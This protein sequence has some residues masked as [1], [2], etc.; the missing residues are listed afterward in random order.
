MNHELIELTNAELFAKSLQR[1]GVEY[2]F[3][4][5]NPSKI[6]LACMDLGIKQIGYRQENSGSYMAQ[7]YGMVTGKV[8][9]VTA[10]NGPAATLLVPGLAECLKASHP[11]VA[12]VQQISLE[13]YE[14]NAFQ[15][16]DHEKLFAG[17]A[18]WVKT[19][20]SA[21]RI[22]DYIDMAFTQAATGKPGPAVLLC[23]VNIFNDRN[24]YS[25]ETGRTKNLGY[26]PLDRV[27]ANP[28]K[29][30]EAA[31]LLA[32][33]KKPMIVAGGGAIA[34]DAMQEIREIQDKYSIPVA[35]TMMGKGSVAEEHPLSVGVIGFITGKRGMAKFL[36]PMVQESDVILFVGSRTNQNG[37]DSWTLFPKTAK[38]IH[39]DVD[40]SEIG[41]NYEAL[42]LA[43]D[44]KLT[45]KALSDALVSEDMSGHAEKRKE[46]EEIIAKGKKE[47][48]EE[49]KDVMTSKEL[50][51]RIEHFT[52][53]LEN[54]LREDHIVVADA[55]FS[56]IWLA[57]YI[58]ATAE[59]KFI[60]PRGIA[61]LGWGLPMAMGAKVGKPNRKVFCMAGDGGFAHVWSELETCRR[62]G[63]N[64]VCAVINNE[65]LGY[66]YWAELSKFDG[67][68]TNACDLSPVNHAK[69]AE[70]CGIK[71][72]RLED[73]NDIDKVLEE[74]M[75][76]DG[77][78]VIDIRATGD[79]IPPVRI[80]ESFDG[81]KYTPIQE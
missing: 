75:N 80:M 7:A 77:C 65:V 42:R 62:H 24:K 43:G 11:I 81:S 37:T 22:E 39:I 16:L 14:K 40:G 38:Y 18:K 10:Q 63:I 78:V 53:K 2:I 79:S 73:P 59:R 23:P 41:R 12:V 69:I 29:I 15:E 45:L 68:H 52:A 50:P 76:F 66:Q 60:F 32:S 71:G 33:A 44:A 55:S 70:A 58:K 51:I 30:K 17:C 3:G 57:N 35:T 36:R 6:T 31:S 64:V 19:I 27:V 9:V 20:Y 72:I 21:D 25:R 8:P 61:G 56:S 46:R 4:Q 1:N 67:C 5:S 26:Y 47:H 48:M 13:D 28:E 74:A 54:Y 49:A 34:S